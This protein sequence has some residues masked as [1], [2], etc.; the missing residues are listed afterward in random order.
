VTS[1]AEIIEASLKAT[2]SIDDQQQN[3]GIAST[4]RST[5]ITIPM[6]RAAVGTVPP[7]WPVTCQYWGLDQG[8]NEHWIAGIKFRLRPR[9]AGERIKELMEQ[10]LAAHREVILLKSIPESSL[11]SH[12]VGYDGGCADVDPGRADAARWKSSLKG[13]MLADQRGQREMATD[14]VREGSVQVGGLPVAVSLIDHHQVQTYLLNLFCTSCEA[15]GHPLI[16]LPTT[17][18]CDDFGANSA[19][20]HLTTSDR[21]P[22]N[23]AWSRPADH[24]DDL[25]KA[26]VF[27]EVRFYARVFG[28][29]REVGDLS[30][31]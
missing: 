19:T 13:V 29:T 24:K 7:D 30:L 4:A 18:D 28:L 5:G 21:N 12:T 26:L 11:G 9:Y 15:T 16:S 2:N 3:L 8:T 25:L 17:V 6:L 23:G 20:K 14:V 1:A 22:E 10:Y 27:A 31:L